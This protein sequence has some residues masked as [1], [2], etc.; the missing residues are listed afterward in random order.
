MKSPHKKSNSGTWRSCQTEEVG[1]EGAERTKS[2]VGT[3]VK[4]AEGDSQDC[5][6]ASNRD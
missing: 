6:S 2:L 5:S 1:G 4:S 3:P